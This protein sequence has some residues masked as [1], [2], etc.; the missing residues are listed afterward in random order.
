MGP[1]DLIAVRSITQRLGRGGLALLVLMSMAAVAIMLAALA[2]ELTAPAAEPVLT[3][4][5]RW[6]NRG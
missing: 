6:L 1:M 5:V 2:P 4:P 3:G